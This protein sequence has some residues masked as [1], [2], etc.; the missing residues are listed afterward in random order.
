MYL[1]NTSNNYVLM[2]SDKQKHER[3]QY[4]TYTVRTKN[5]GQNAHDTLQIFVYEQNQDRKTRLL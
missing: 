1:P 2:Y 3:A 5:E 4:N